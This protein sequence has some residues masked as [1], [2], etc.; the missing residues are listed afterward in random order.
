M[1]DQDGTGSLD[2]KSF[3][4][5]LDEFRKTV[6]NM[7]LREEDV[8]A[9]NAGLGSLDR[10]IENMHVVSE[11][12]DAIRA[13][14]LKPVIAKM[15]LMEKAGMVGLWLGLLALVATIV[16]V[17]DGMWTKHELRSNV[18]STAIEQ[19][20]GVSLAP[21]AE[22]QFVF[23]N[24]I[25]GIALSPD[26]RWIAYVVSTDRARIWVRRVDDTNGDRDTSEHP[27]QKTE[28]AAYPFW[29][30]DS[31]SIGF[32][33]D[34][35]LKRADL[36]G[37]DPIAICKV[38][39]GRGGTWTDHE[40]IIFGT[41][42]SGLS[43]VSADGKNSPTTLT[44][45]DT[46]R[47]ETGH[48]WPQMLPGDRF[49]YWVR[50]DDKDNEGVYAASLASPGVSTLV[51]SRTETNAVYAH[52]ADGRN[53]LLWLLNGGLWAQPFDEAALR[54]NGDA[55]EI[56]FPVSMIGL[57]GRANVAIPANG[58]LLYSRFNTLSQFVWFS[59]DGTRIRSAGEP[60]QYTTFRISP[61][62]GRIV[63]ST[64]KPGG[65]DLRMDVQAQST[66][67]ISNRGMNS[68]PIWSPD[69]RAV[70]YTSPHLN[71]FLKTLEGTD[72]AK[73]LTKSPNAQYATDWSKDGKSI[74]YWEVSPDKARRQ[75]WTLSME[76]TNPGAANSVAKPY[77]TTGHND[78]WGRFSPEAGSEWVAY[79]SD[80]SG[81]NE[82]Y[83][84]QFPDSTGNSTR[85]SLHGGQYPAWNPNGQEIFY[86]SPDYKLMAVSLKR[87]PSS[88]TPGMSRVVLQLPAVDI[89]WPPYDVDAET[90]R[91]L[92]RAIPDQSPKPLT[93]VINWTLL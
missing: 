67:I 38:A 35:E 2:G 91:I 10:S 69:G 26:G 89:G 51:K 12:V 65:T 74:L 29:S 92:V 73:P 82:I 31:K 24:N 76:T 83:V 28:G 45:L 6:R 58:L 22:G 77:M 42:L 60:S 1:D 8:R 4:E 32:F 49:I 18:R 71:L 34:G 7:R 75:L 5:A 78:S 15:R 55:R 70:L 84:R 56:A 36:L 50:S 3:R 48:S 62:G 63:A 57:F 30:P 88:I 17:A 16:D 19:H 39:I 81:H 43:K 87:E 85:I 13:E 11:K 93:L 64:D 54:T 90:G 80:E 59:P 20:V 9:I 27:L 14:I 33:A 23:G 37:G 47:G 41:L 40:E 21:P 52:G 72:A 44:T 53:Y 79:E 68:Y 66:A 25:G 46:R 61:T 86:V